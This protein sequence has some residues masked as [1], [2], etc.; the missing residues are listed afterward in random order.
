M[1]LSKIRGPQSNDNDAR[2]ARARTRVAGEA[3]PGEGGT[4]A[5]EPSDSVSISGGARDLALEHRVL[6]DRV[7]DLDAT[8]SLSGAAVE[9]L[10]DRL[11]SGD[12]G[13]REILEDCARRILADL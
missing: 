7:L 6:V 5:L 4:G 13:R 10:R 3:R 9:A 8:A 2:V 12:L 1:D 11:A